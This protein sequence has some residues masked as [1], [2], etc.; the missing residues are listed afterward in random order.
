MPYIRCIDSF[1]NHWHTMTSREI[2]QTRLDCTV[3]LARERLVH[4]T[5]QGWKFPSPLELSERLL[6]ANILN[7]LFLVS[8]LRTESSFGQ[9]SVLKRRAAAWGETKSSWLI[10]SSSKACSFT[11]YKLFSP[12]CRGPEERKWDKK[13]MS[14]LSHETDYLTDEHTAK[15]ESKIRCISAGFSR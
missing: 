3:W 1:R 14:K 9:F 13:N 12:L 15:M 2:S 4:I 7:E 5:Q 10:T 6:S 11:Q 8:S